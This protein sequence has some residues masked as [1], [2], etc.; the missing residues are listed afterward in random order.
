MDILKIRFLPRYLI[1]YNQINIYDNIFILNSAP[2]FQFISVWSLWGTTID[3]EVL[4]L[5]K[6]HQ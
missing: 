5:K 3:K 6:M 4:P 1:L 2:T